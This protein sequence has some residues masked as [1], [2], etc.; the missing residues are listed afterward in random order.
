MVT[1]DPYVFVQIKSIKKK[2]SFKKKRAEDG[3]AY[4][5]E[6]HEV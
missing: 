6:D 4:L 5:G 2:N 3:V 1:Q